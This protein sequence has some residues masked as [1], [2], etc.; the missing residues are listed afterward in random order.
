MEEVSSV[1]TDVFH[2][3]MTDKVRKCVEKLSVGPV[4]A[5]ISVTGKNAVVIGRSKIV[6]APM[7]DLLMWNHATVTCCHSKTL[8]L[9]GEVLPLTLT[10]FLLLLF[11]FLSLFCFLF[12][13]AV[14]KSPQKFLGGE[15]PE[16]SSNRICLL[17][18]GEEGRHPGGRH[19]ES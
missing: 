13:S 19:W 8:D 16:R 7:H 3:C 14:L 10:H 18:V 12:L 15:C 11:S 9:P 1:R 5:G 17:C 4:C 2:I 6:G